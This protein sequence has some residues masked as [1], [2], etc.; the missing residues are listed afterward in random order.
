MK[1]SRYFN[2]IHIFRG[3]NHSSIPDGQSFTGNNVFYRQ[4]SQGNSC[5]SLDSYESNLVDEF[6]EINLNQSSTNPSL[7]KTQQGSVILKL[8]WND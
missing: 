6:N 7:S 1:N 5:N 2:F 3:C 4:N 8:V